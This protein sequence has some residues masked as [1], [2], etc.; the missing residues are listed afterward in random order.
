MGSCADASGVQCP[1]QT[2]IRVEGK[3]S[4][5]HEDSPVPELPSPSCPPELLYVAVLCGAAPWLP[6]HALFVE[7]PIF[8]RRLSMHRQIGAM[9]GA[10]VQLANAVPYLYVAAVPPHRLRVPAA[11]AACMALAVACPVVAAF[12]WTDSTGLLCAAFAAG[13][14]ACTARVIWLHF[15]GAHFHEAALLPLAAGMGLSGIAVAAAGVVQQNSSNEEAFSA[16]SFLFNAGLVDAVAAA[17]LSLALLPRVRRRWRGA[18]GGE[19]SPLLHAAVGPAAARAE[20]QLQHNGGLR[21]STRPGSPVSLSRTTARSW[22]AG[23]LTDITVSFTGGLPSPDPQRAEGEPG[24]AVGLCRAW[25][26][27]PGPIAAAACS[28]TL[29]CAAL[30]GVLP[31]LQPQLWRAAWGG[32]LYSV[33]HAAG[34]MA[35]SCGAPCSPAVPAAGQVCVA[36]YLAFLATGNGGQAVDTGEGHIGNTALPWWWLSVGLPVACFAFL[37]GLAA[38]ASAQHVHRSKGGERAWSDAAII[39]RGVAAASQL[40]G[41]LGTAAS[42]VTAVGGGFTDY[43]D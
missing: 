39:A 16:R 23:A 15:F 29:C 26:L 9:L 30:P 4:P 5:P 32:M 33:A 6:V 28:S 43:H 12:T 22:S 3:V 21:S 17:A 34:R 25:E 24:E 1:P 2:V 8:A 14:T 19:R 20:P 11:A 7:V 27:A 31:Y 38:S 40:G 37:G 35:A 13:T 42:L 41:A 36:A 18:T 10:M